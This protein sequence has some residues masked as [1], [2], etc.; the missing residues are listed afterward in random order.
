MGLCLEPCLWDRTERRIAL[1][2]PVSFCSKAGA[3]NLKITEP[4]Y[5]AHRAKGFTQAVKRSSSG[6]TWG[7]SDCDSSF[8][9]MGQVGN[10]PCSELSYIKSSSQLQNVANSCSRGQ[11]TIH[12]IYTS[13]RA[14][15]SIQA[16]LCHPVLMKRHSSLTHLHE[17]GK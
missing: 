1:Y 12:A 11:V 9:G 14:Y 2:L 8:R 6:S 15:T 7:R 17:S 3:R 13:G 16:Q 10:N 4:F 5:P